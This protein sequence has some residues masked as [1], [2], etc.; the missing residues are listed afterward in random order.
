[1]RALAG[2]AFSADPPRRAAAAADPRFRAV[3]AVADGTPTPHVLAIDDGA[4]DVRLCSVTAPAGAA[5]ATLL[6]AA[7]C[8]TSFV[9]SGGVVTT[10][11]G[12]RSDWRL[13]L[14]RTP[15]QSA[16]EA[17]AIAFGDMVGL[18]ASSR[19]R[20]PAGSPGPEGT[21]GRPG[22]T[23]PTGARGPRGPRA[24][25]TCTVRSRRR[26]TCRVKSTASARLVRRG[27]VYA[28]G[29]AK[30]LRARR[31][32]R[33]GRYTLRVSDGRGLLVTVR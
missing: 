1:M 9:A 16:S 31:E 18:R 14:N 23:G 30:R 10:I 8:V 4:G 3:P 19:L 13:R 15:E 12:R 27:R 28:T 20:G 5:L 33:P 24:R 26:V 17:R 32:L 7:P 21:P 11:D 2:E 25:V 29:T 22:A 6:A